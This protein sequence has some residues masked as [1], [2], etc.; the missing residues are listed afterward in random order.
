M[1]PDDNA[2]GETPLEDD[3]ASARCTHSP[4][5][6]NRR[7]NACPWDPWQRG[8]HPRH[9]PPREFAARDHAR[10]PGIPESPPDFLQ[11]KRR[12]I[13]SC[14]SRSCAVTYPC[15]TTR[16]SMFAAAMC[17]TPCTSR[18]TVTGCDNPATCSLPSS[19]GREVRMACRSHTVP[20]QHASATAATA[21]STADINQRA[22]TTGELSFW[23][24]RARKSDIRV[25]S[26][27]F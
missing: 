26:R 1:A 9:G 3:P 19:W 12:S 2:A 7:G 14:H 4:R 5:A 15:A 18:R 21:I 8:R 27:A 25:Q 24:D 20:P 6:H 23:I 17:G 11:A 16:S 13:S 10:S 22:R